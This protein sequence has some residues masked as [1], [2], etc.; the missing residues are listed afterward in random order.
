MPTRPKRLQSGDTIA[1]VSPSSPPANAKNIDRAVAMLETL[2][3]HV[4]LGAN[5]RKRNGFLAGSDR[6]RAGD[7]M[8]AFTDRKVNA[9]LCV[10]GG[11]GATRLLPLLDYAAIRR[12]PKIFVGYSDITALH[13][14]LLKK[15]NLI[16]FHG[17]TL[18]A[19][20][21]TNGFSRFV[22]ESFFRT[23]RAPEAAGSICHGKVKGVS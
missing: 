12:N 10:R 1:I 16:T 14:A 11:H 3:F 5:A 4:Q 23:L 9:I 6:E 19:D 2:G 17:P 15:A 13:C 8:R 20:F 7:L 21:V 22:R 18:N